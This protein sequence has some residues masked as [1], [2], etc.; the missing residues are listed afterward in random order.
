V[1]AAA[2]ECGLGVYGMAPYRMSADVGQGLVF[3]YAG[4]AEPA[5]TE[6]VDILAD[7]IA[8]LRGR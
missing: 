7:V 1:V 2:A 6:G 8:D 4:L 3:G 5:I